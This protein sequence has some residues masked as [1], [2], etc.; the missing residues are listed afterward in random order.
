MPMGEGKRVDL[1]RSSTAHPARRVI[2]ASHLV[3]TGY[4]HWLS[5]DPRGSGS[6]SIRKD[7]LKPLGEIHLGR[8]RIQPPKQD[9][10]QF[11]REAEPL[12]DHETVWF[13]AFMRSAI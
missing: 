6:Q 2:L 5:N 3:F 4:A 12:L 13:D 1:R 7:D 8:K 9:V 11:Y 10:K